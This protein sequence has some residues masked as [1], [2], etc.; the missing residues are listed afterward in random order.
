MVLLF[1]WIVFQRSD[2]E[3]GFLEVLQSVTLNAFFFFA[4]AYLTAYLLVPA[5]FKKGKYV[6]LVVV[7]LISGLAISY[8]KFFASDYLFYGAI[9]PSVSTGTSVVQFREILVNT[10]DMTFIVALFVIARY[11][12]GNLKM[13][14]KLAEL[15]DLQLRSEIKL[16]KNQLDPHVVFN[17]LNNIYSLAL[18]NSDQL[19]VNIQRFRSVLNYYL[20]QGK[21]ETV[22]LKDELNAISNYV[23]LEKIR[24]GDRLEVDMRFEG[25]E[26][27][28][29]VFPFTLFSFVENCF[30]HGCSLDSGIS[31]LKI[32]I[33]TEHSSVTFHAS[34]SKPSIPPVFG[35][36][37]E[38]FRKVTPVNK[39][40]LLYPGRYLFRT[41][42]KPE[43]YYVDL[44]IKF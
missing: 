15:R 38:E 37:E 36:E 9:N 20:V 2:Q 32:Y 21:G 4:Y 8:L 13:R 6:L 11:S 14:T 28:H 27:E 29:R 34:N 31:W 10:K 39:L 25:E 5:F 19:Q 30:E 41:E 35:S 42:E 43:A 18:S 1:T 26:Y 3:R 44:K 22:L 23:N 7:F 24:Y 16:L 12:G 17:N 33:R 40:E